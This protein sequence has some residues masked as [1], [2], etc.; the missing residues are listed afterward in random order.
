MK[1]SAEEK[2]MLQSVAKLGFPISEELAKALC[3]GLKQIRTAKHQEN[4]ERKRRLAE[5]QANHPCR[6]YR[7]KK[8][9]PPSV[10]DGNP[11]LP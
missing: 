1:R 6:H 4:T 5:Q 10:C 8:K 3:D 9:K 2:I 7:R 11:Q